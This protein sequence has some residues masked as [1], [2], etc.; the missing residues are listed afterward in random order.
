M[1][2]GLPNEHYISD[3]V[4]DEEKKAILFNNWSAIGF[5]KDIPNTGDIKPMSFVDMPLLMARDENN[6]INVFQNT[7]RHRG[8]ILIEEPEKSIRT[9]YLSIS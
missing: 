3:A 5:G 8:M 1:A 2:K 7:C 4:F 9:N 6:N